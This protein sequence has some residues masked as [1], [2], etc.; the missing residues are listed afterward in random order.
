MTVESKK[1]GSSIKIYINNL[2]HLFIADRITSLQSWNME[3]Q[4]W[5]IEIT[6]KN[7]KIKL[8]Y[9]SQTKWEQVLNELNK[10]F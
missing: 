3:D 9:D 8:E 7:N 6:T 10:L 4:F 5:I 1:S 2:L